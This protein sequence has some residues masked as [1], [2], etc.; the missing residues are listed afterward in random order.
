MRDAAIPKEDTMKTFAAVFLLLSAASATAAPI[1]CPGSKDLTSPQDATCRGVRTE[2]NR[3]CA[4]TE[5]ETAASSDLIAQVNA[6]SCAEPCLKRGGA[7][8]TYA[9]ATTVTCERQWWTLW[10]MVVCEAHATGNATVVCSV[11]G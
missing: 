7:P 10:I 9:P 11:E 4:K 1:A 3:R 8:V 2:A 5:A 6:E